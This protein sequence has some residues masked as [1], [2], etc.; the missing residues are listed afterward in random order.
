MLKLLEGKIDE[1]KEGKRERRREERK[2][3]LR[4]KNI[5]W[6]AGD[7]FVVVVKEKTVTSIVLKLSHLENH[8]TPNKEWI[9]SLYV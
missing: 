6:K 4:S 7:F 3:I 9:S 2:K 8:T 5:G 1:E